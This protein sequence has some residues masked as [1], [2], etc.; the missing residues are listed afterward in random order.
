VD[1]LDIGGQITIFSSHAAQSIS[2]ATRSAE[3][4]IRVTPPETRSVAAAPRRS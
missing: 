2:A 1:E 3:A 4:P